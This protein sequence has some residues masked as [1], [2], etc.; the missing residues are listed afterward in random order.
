[1]MVTNKADAIHF[2]KIILD[3]C[4]PQ[5]ARMMMD[6][7]DFYIAETTDNE[8]VKESIK[9]IREMVYAKAE[10]NLEIE[11]EEAEWQSAQDIIDEQ[12]KIGKPE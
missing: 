5:V 12:R 2:M 6:D 11:A 7:L 10:E 3:W 9:M 4:S 1:M 8:S